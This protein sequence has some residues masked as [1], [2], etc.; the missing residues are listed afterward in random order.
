MMLL[1]ML[2]MV[3]YGLAMPVFQDDPTRRQQQDRNQQRNQQRNQR[4]QQNRNQATQ[5]GN[6]N[7]SDQQQRNQNI[8]EQPILDNDEEIPDSLLH[9]RWKIQRTTPITYDDLGQRT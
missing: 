2:I 5:N 3:S 4:R 6:Q 9:P 1:A 7:G 8:T